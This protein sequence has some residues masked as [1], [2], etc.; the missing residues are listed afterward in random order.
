M[1]I[2]CGIHDHHALKRSSR[3]KDKRRERRQR[4]RQRMGTPMAGSRLRLNA[5]AV[6]LAASIVFGGIG[7]EAFLIELAS[8]PADPLV[9]PRPAHKSVAS[10]KSESDR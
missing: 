3:R 4:Q 1:R 8:R 2:F 9:L 6:A 5:A 10:G 7:V